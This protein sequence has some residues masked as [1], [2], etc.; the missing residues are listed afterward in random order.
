MCWQAAVPSVT[1]CCLRIGGHV[2]GDTF[3]TLA[4]G[5]ILALARAQEFLECPSGSFPEA[6]FWPAITSG[7]RVIRSQSRTAASEKTDQDGTNLSVVP[8]SYSFLGKSRW[9]HLDRNPAGRTWGVTF[10]PAAGPTQAGGGVAFEASRKRPLPGDRGE[11]R[12]GWDEYYM[13]SWSSS[14]AA[15]ALRLKSLAGRTLF[16]PG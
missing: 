12:G 1:T 15:G 4:F 2:L 6:D 16:S 13:P 11:G 7:W 9:S 10:T 14:S 3:G 8:T 5:T